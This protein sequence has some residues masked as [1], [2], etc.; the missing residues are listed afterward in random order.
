MA[1]QKS[2]PVKPPIIDLEAKKAKGDDAAQPKTENLGNRARAYM[3]NLGDKLDPRRFVSNLSFM[4]TLFGIFGGAFLGLLF[5]Y[6][7]AVAGFWPQKTPEIV[8][9][10][11]AADIAAIDR[12]MEGLEAAIRAGATGLSE[13]EANLSSRLNDQTSQLSD[14]DIAITELQA[15]ITKLQTQPVVAPDTASFDLINDELAA[16]STRIDAIAAGTTS[17]DASALVENITSLQSQLAGLAKQVSKFETSIGETN[18]NVTELENALSTLSVKIENQPK[19]EQS[20]P[21]STQLPLALSSFERAISTGRPFS[22]ELAALSLSLPELQIPPALSQKAISGLAAPDRLSR[23][24]MA[25]IPAMLA[26]RPIDTD[27]A[28]QDRLLDR[29]QSLLA[30]RPSGDIEG[31]SPEAIIARLEAAVARRDF[32]VAATQIAALPDRMRTAAGVISAQIADLA[33]AQSFAAQVRHLA[34]APPS[35]ISAETAQ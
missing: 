35:N 14:R 33:T 25:N 31:N 23:D 10:N 26:A 6:A 32:I 27:R 22:A 18:A 30:I 2:G 4:P 34:L 21:P 20:S 9:S 5:A 17:N 3:G 28:W 12:R 15:A 29:A 1:E 19:P 11:T 7:L 16:L 8:Q 24:L 13:L